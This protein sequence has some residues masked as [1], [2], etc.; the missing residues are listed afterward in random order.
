[1]S[2]GTQVCAEPLLRV[3]PKEEARRDKFILH[4]KF[5]GSAICFC[6]RTL[7]WLQNGANCSEKIIQ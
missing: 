5:G 7:V 3:F 2:A 1:M 6:V 4:L